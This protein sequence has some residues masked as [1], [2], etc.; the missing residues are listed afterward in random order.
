MAYVDPRPAEDILHF[1]VEDS[2]FR[3]DRLM[4]PIGQDQVVDAF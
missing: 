3:V 4:N 1:K 2:G